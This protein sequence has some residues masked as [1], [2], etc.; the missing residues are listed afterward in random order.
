[1]NGHQR[2]IAMRRGGIKPTVVWVNDMAGYAP[3]ADDKAVAVSVHGDTPEMLDF[4]FLQGIDRVILESASQARIDRLIPV[5][6][7]HVRS[8]WA[9]TWQDENTP[10]SVRITK[11]EGDTTTCSTT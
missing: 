5:L 11:T 9:T 4:S 7:A 6:M 10:R 2:I 8:V 3:D 1:M